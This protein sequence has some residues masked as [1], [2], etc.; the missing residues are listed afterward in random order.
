[1]LTSRLRAVVIGKLVRS[2]EPTAVAGALRRFADVKAATPTPDR[3]KPPPAEPAVDVSLLETVLRAGVEHGSAA[4]YEY[5]AASAREATSTEAQLR[6]L[7][8]LGGARDTSLQQR[9]LELAL[10]TE[11]RAQDAA[12]CFGAVCDGGPEGQRLAWRFFMD[13]WDTIDAKFGKGGSKLLGK[14]VDALARGRITAEQRA[15]LEAFF[16]AHPAPAAAQA[17]EQALESIELRRAWA[18]RD[19]DDAL[20]GL[21]EGEKVF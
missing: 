18:E 21:Q 10:S 8:A 12:T 11:V 15:E 14:F 17:V 4:D 2:G 6:C 7:R 13:R 19:L 20:R 9:T 5:V 3:T 16:V 1:M